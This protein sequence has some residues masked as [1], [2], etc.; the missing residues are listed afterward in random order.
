MTK[1]HKEILGL[2]RHLH[3]LDKA[4][5]LQMEMYVK[6]YQII[7]CKYVQ[8]IVCHYTPIKLLKQDI[9]GYLSSKSSMFLVFLTMGGF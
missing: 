1:E 9:K 2:G 5:D 4:T 8:I 7:H 3:Y 6:I